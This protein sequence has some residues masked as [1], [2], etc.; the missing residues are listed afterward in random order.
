MRDLRVL[1]GYRRSD[2]AVI[3]CYGGIGDE[4]CGVFMLPSPVAG[5]L[6]VIASSG[7]GWDHVSVSGRDRCPTWHEME[8]VRRRFFRDDEAVMQYHAPLADYVD[9]TKLGCEHCLH[10]WRPHDAAIPAP[11]KWMVGG[12]TQEEAKAGRLR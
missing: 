3:A 4:T 12:M 11:P 9:G 6:M 7:E 5:H 8:H 1:D 10:L 2:P